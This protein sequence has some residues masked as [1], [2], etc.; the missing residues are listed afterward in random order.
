M[1]EAHQIGPDVTG[2][3]RPAALHALRLGP[4]SA[5]VDRLDNDR[6]IHLER[7]LALD[8]RFARAWTLLARV[9]LNAAINGWSDDRAR[10][11]ELFHE[12]ARRAAELGPDDGQALVV[13]GMSH[14]RRGQT[15]L[16][17]QAWDRAVAPSPNDDQV[18]RAVGSAL[19]IALGVERATEGVALVERALL[20]LSPLHPPARWF[21]L[22]DAL[23]FAG[24]YA[25]AVGV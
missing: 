16:G 6:A 19:P 9:H 20:R 4:G 5:D 7:A 17:A 24:R 12:A 11:W 21:F 23:Y 1:I 22:G 2:N 15:A 13:L 18:L 25:D 14:F 10:R 3:L 8:P